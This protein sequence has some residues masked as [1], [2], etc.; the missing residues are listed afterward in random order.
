MDDLS[1]RYSIL[2]QA[3]SL[4]LITLTQFGRA[5]AGRFGRGVG[6]GR[7]SLCTSQPVHNAAVPRRAQA[8]KSDAEADHDGP[9]QPLR[10]RPPATRPNGPVVD[11]PP[12]A[13]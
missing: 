8:R 11:P 12:I 2:R 4:R 1:S 3:Q 7:P 5:S 9:S 6:A 10:A 13:T